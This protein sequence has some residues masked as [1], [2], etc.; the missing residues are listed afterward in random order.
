MCATAMS[1]VEAATI[2]LETALTDQLIVSKTYSSQGASATVAGNVGSGSGATTLG[3]SSSVTGTVTHGTSLTLGVGAAVGGSIMSTVV[4]PTAPSLQSNIQSQQA[5]LKAITGSSILGVISTNTSFTAGVH[6]VVDILSIAANLDITLT[7]DGSDQSWV[8]NVGNYLSIGANTNIVLDNVGENSSVIW[9]VL[10]DSTGGAGL[11]YASLG[12]GGSCGGLYSATSYISV[13]ATSVVGGD[14]CSTTT[15][16][17][18]VPVAV[19]L[20]GSGLLGLVG[21]ARRK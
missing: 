11:G 20:F 7:G 21:A 12:V 9:N 6:N 18:P 19:W 5:A 3:A 17:V 10:G 14:G 13:G 15:T 1:S 16:V 8:F 4:V 2:V